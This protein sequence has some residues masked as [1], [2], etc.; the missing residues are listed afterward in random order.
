MK[1][2]LFGV[3]FVGF[4]T[5]ANPCIVLPTA[6]GFLRGDLVFVG[7]VTGVREVKPQTQG[8]FLRLI[9]SVRPTSV[10]K[11]SAQKEVKIFAILDN[12]MCEDDQLLS[13]HEYI[14]SPSQ[15]LASFWLRGDDPKK[16]GIASREATIFRT[17]VGA[18]LDMKDRG[19][20]KL[21]EEIKQKL[22]K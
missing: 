10:L 22:K 7:K 20:P 6:E 12:S 17:D 14:F 11:G 3:L 21:L 13:G 5:T 15:S 9:Y 8:Q 1:T 4:A 2:A 19:V 18:S 16:Y